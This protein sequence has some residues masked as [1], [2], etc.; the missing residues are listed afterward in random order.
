MDGTWK[1]ELLLC[2][3]RSWLLEDAI[4]GVSGDG[5]GDSCIMEGLNCLLIC[6]RGND[7]IGEVRGEGGEEPRLKGVFDIAWAGVGREYCMGRVR[8]Y[9]GTG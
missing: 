3:G 5:V 2:D 7:T 8:G 9:E 6:V 4:V 1:G